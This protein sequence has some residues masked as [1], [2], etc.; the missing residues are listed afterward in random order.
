[1]PLSLAVIEGEFSQVPEAAALYL[2]Q[3]G[4]FI[5]LSPCLSFLL[6]AGQYRGI[7]DFVVDC[8]KK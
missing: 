3:V 7:I 4:E 5:V 1:L 8:Y 6:K 2:G